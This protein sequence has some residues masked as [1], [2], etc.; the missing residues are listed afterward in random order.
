M[1]PASR[2]CGFGKHW[3][4]ASVTFRRRSM[5]RLPLW[6]IV[7]IHHRT[8]SCDTPNPFC[9]HS[10]G[11]R[12]L[13]L[14]SVASRSCAACRFLLN[15]RKRCESLSSRSRDEVEGGPGPQL[16]GFDGFVGGP[17]V[18]LAERALIRSRIHPVNPNWL[19]GLHSH[20]PSGV[21]RSGRA[22]GRGYR[23]PG[24]VSFTTI[25]N[26]SRDSGET[27]QR[28]AGFSKNLVFAKLSFG[29]RVPRT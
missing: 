5:F 22:L 26:S 28:A 21:P 16:P 13:P 15:N 4:D 29:A 19:T 17:G 8:M 14:R 2:R 27:R 9:P 20:E 25:S 24:L 6:A 23:R 10:G 1:R 3:R 12:V 18:R 7:D 11:D